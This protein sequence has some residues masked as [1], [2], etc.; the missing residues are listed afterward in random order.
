MFSV[1][2]ITSKRLLSEDKVVKREDLG[3][4]S[5]VR[6]LKCKIDFLETEQ[7]QAFKSVNDKEKNSQPQLVSHR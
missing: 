5:C 6:V 7:P 1:L 2:Q 4:P 3:F